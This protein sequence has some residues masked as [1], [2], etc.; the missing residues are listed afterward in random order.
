MNEDRYH[1]VVEESQG[2]AAMKGK[3]FVLRKLKIVQSLGVNRFVVYRPDPPGKS[4]GGSLEVI[5]GEQA[6]DPATAIEQW[7]ELLRYQI[8]RRRIEI[9]DREAQLLD[10]QIEYPPGQDRDD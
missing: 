6:H 10:P 5:I 1:Y 4:L 8:N 3:P 2:L 9:R 7:K